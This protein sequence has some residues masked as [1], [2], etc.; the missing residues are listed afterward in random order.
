M[1]I[2]WVGAVKIEKKKKAIVPLS[3]REKKRYI[4]I[5]VLNAN[6]TEKDFYFGFWIEM[7]SL[8]GSKGLAEMAPKLVLYKE[9]KGI[10]KC[11]RGKETELIAGLAF[12]RKIRNKKVIINTLAVSGTIRK[13]KE[14]G[15][16][17]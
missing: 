11:R 10:L 8:F 6:L 3:M 2:F 17:S 16:I 7:L 1:E 9:N 13:L 5:E 14:I 12:I 15:K 4:L